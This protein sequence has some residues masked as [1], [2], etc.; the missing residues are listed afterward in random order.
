L[1]KPKVTMKNTCKY[2]FV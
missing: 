1:C 2:W